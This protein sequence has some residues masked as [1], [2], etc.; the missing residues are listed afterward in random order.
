MSLIGSAFSA[1]GSGLKLFLVGH[2]AD[3][4][5]K[6][7]NC[8]A[9]ESLGGFKLV[10]LLLVLSFLAGAAVGVTCLGGCLGLW[11]FH[12]EARCPSPLRGKHGR[13]GRRGG[14]GG[15]SI[16]LVKQNIEVVK[17][18]TDGMSSRLTSLRYS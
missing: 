5:T 4:V 11:H 16:E 2:A 15:G 10:F 6:A 8:T 17:L 18:G 12:R 3:L 9:F 14:A 7:G 13:S 1:L